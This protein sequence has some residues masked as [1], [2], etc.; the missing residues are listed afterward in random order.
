M[1]DRLTNNIEHHGE[2]LTVRARRQ[3]VLSTNLANAD[4]PGFQARDISFKDELAAQLKNGGTQTNS[5]L[6]TSNARHIPLSMSS[7][8]PGSLLTTLKYRARDQAS[9]DDNSVNLDRERANFAENS[10]RYEASLRFI[11]S[12]TKKIISAIRGE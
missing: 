9:L 4:T 3:Q 7:D 8:G 11:N 5:R 6:S 12:S 10:L 1:L 2:V